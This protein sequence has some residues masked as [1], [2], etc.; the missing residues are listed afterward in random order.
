MSK[1][2]PSALVELPSLRVEVVEPGKKQRKGWLR[3]EIGTNVEFNTER[4]QS[5]FFAEWKPVLYDALLVAAVIE[6]CDRSQRR[7]ATGWGRTF[8]VR[9][10]VHQPERWNQRDVMDALHSVVNF[11]TGDRWQ[12]SFYGRRRKESAPLQG[13]FSLG[14]NKVAVLPFSD[15]LDSS[16]VA[17]LLTREL[18]DKLVRVRLGSKDFNGSGLPKGR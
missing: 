1:A 13:Q 18:G 12:I 11:L 7:P 14:N 9:I 5:Y 4:M 3:C 8:E 6:F 10:P 17:G 16:A 15:G 2:D